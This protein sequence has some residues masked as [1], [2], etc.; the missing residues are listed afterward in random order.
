MFCSGKR[1]W[2]AFLGTR[3]GLGRAHSPRGPKAGTR[4]DLSSVHTRGRPVSSSPTAADDA[5]M[6]HSQ[7]WA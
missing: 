3:R 7:L 4:L 2:N 6:T 5:P 1:K